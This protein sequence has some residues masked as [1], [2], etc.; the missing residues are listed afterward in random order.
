[1]NTRWPYW[2]ALAIILLL[3]LFL[4]H[5]RLGELPMEAHAW[6]QTDHFSLA[7][8]FERNGLNFFKP[9]TYILNHQFPYNFLRPAKNSITSVDFPVHEYIPA[10]F[11][12]L[13]GTRSPMVFRVYVLL[14]SIIG[15]FYLFRLALLITGDEIWSLAI[16]LWSSTVP[17]YALFQGSF[18]PSIPSLSLMII[19][20]YYYFHHVE[21]EERKPFITAIIFLTIAALTR[22]TFAIPLVAIG[23]Y[24]I[25]GTFKQN[26]SSNS[27]KI[28][29]YIL[30]LL[31]FLSYQVYNHYLFYNY[32]SVFLNYFL[33]PHN[34][35]EVQN[36]LTIIRDKWLLTFGSPFHYLLLMTSIVLIIKYFKSIISKKNPLHRAVLMI[37]SLMLLGDFIFFGMMMKQWEHH[38]YY[39][40]DTFYMPTLLLV[41][42]AFSQIPLR[43]WTHWKRLAIVGGILLSGIYTAVYAQRAKADRANINMHSR[44]YA[45]YR[46]FIGTGAFL[47]SLGIS[48]DAKILVMDA[49]APNLPFLLMDRK[50]MAIMSTTVR[51]LDEAMK[52]KFDLLALQDTFILSDIYPNAPNIIHR[53]KKIASNGKVN[54]YKRAPKSYVGNLETFLGLDT[55]R[56]VFHTEENFEHGEDTTYLSPWE[57]PRIVPDP[58]RANNHIMYLKEG[59]EFGMKWEHS[60]PEILSD[61]SML[62]FKGKFKA[63]TPDKIFI[64]TTYGRFITNDTLYKAKSIEQQLYPFKKW[65]SIALKIPLEPSISRTDCSLS[66]YIWNEKKRKILMDDIGFSIYKTD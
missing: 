53:F 26:K 2:T 22:K 54:F 7:L 38:D 48:K 43:E 27:Y 12:K 49:Y 39:L 16:L 9:E 8:G 36:L 61:Y 64:V 30:M 66:V 60:C 63:F 19:G 24:E 56:R 3:T 5:K 65:R 14:L 11:M 33:P 44:T 47:D 23:V 34:S 28:A 52:W 45:T 31:V 6:A 10:I 4:N 17:V 18:M 13:L 46:N 57:F 42:L 41:A 35:V 21:T 40:N 62:I 59:E 50:G 1:M 37:L 55:T 15:L 58:D 32:G 29:T 20:M 25:F 51:N